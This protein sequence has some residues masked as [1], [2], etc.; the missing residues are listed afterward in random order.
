MYDD[1]RMSRADFGNEYAGMVTLR[2]GLAHSLN[3][4]M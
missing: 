1:K 2:R 4:G 3:I